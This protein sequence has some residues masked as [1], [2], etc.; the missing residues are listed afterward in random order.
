MNKKNDIQIIRDLASETK[1][2]GQAIERNLR[3]GSIKVR[4]F[5][6]KWRDKLNVEGIDSEDPNLTFLIFSLCNFIEDFYYNLAGD[7]PYSKEVKEIRESVMKNLGSTFINIS[8]NLETSDFN[9]C[10]E[11]LAKIAYLYL[12]KIKHLNR[13]LKS[14]NS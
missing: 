2:V 4:Q 10:H 8:E 13:I 3:E 11:S 6:G 9:K 12:D 7:F 5:Q 14:K 1:E